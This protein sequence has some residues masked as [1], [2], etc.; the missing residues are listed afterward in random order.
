MM[1][2]QNAQK[3][4][5][6]SPAGTTFSAGAQLGTQAFF[7]AVRQKRFDHEMPWLRELVQFHLFK[8][9]NVL[10]LGCGAGYDAFEF[11]RHGANYV[12]IDITPENPGRVRSH[13]AHYGYCPTVI[14]GDAEALPFRDESFDT[15]YSNGVLHHTPDMHQSLTEAHRVLSKDGTLYLVLYHRNSIF[16]WLTLF[17]F[18]HV[19]HL[20]FLRRSFRSR[21][22]MIE[23]TTAD[24]HPLVKC[25]SRGEVRQQL[26]N[27]GFAVE[28]IQTRK[29]T[30][31]DL[32]GVPLINKLYRYI[33]VQLLNALAKRFGWYLIVR[34]RKPWDSTSRA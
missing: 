22:S 16:H 20:G 30:V 9:K 8:G 7:E 21:L 10:E 2:K 34:A 13:L 32:P 12:G 1:D 28:D 11:H 18:D 24:V 4:W 31:E 3:V 19:F 14:V 6:A 15:V 17:L 5:G 23:Y 33:P 26:E 25:Y 29:L 27:C